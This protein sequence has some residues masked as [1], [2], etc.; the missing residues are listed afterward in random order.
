[1]MVLFSTFIVLAWLLSLLALVLIRPKTK[2]K[3]LPKELPFVSILISLRNEENNVRLLYENLVQLSYSQS[4]F[5]I[6]L[7]DDDSSDQTLE[8][9]EKY[10]PGNASVY[11]FSESETSNLN[12][13]KV[14][15]SLSKMARGEYL[16]FTDADMKFSPDWIQGMLAQCS[17]DNGLM[18]GLTRVSG[19]RWLDRMQNVDWLF[20]EQIIAWFANIGVALTAWGNNMLISK[21]TYDLVRGHEGLNGTIV[22]DVDLLRRVQE[23]KGRLIVNQDPTAVGTTQPIH[24]IRDLLHQRK[25]WMKGLVGI[26]PIFWMAAFIKAL[27]WPCI[28][29]L[30]ILNP[31]W[32]LGI[33]VTLIAK[34]V[35]IKR[36][37]ITTK[38]NHS[39]ADLLTFEIYDF[40]FYLITFAHYLLPVKVVWKGRDY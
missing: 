11:A 33:G 9:L 3:S 20:N 21:H 40:F 24:N 37:F 10:K 38:N 36:A 22:E 27:F 34:S 4:N 35:I 31:L 18:V 5:E 19:E 17:H 12:K 15:S 26:N 16:I 28:I 14:L 30:C 29:Y 1:M 25:R 39:I 2:S 8:L 13:Q 32:L 7:G 6:I 23:N